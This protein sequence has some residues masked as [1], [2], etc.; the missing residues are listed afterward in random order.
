MELSHYIAANSKRARST[1]SCSEYSPELLVGR[2]ILHGFDMNSE[3]RWYAGYVVSYNA[4]TH[5][6]EVAC[7]GEEASLNHPVKCTNYHAGIPRRKI[8]CNAPG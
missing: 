6:H 7:H 8:V 2:E 5:L 4:V 1:E 3:E